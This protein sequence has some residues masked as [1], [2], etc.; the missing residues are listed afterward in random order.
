MQAFSAACWVQPGLGEPV[1]VSLGHGASPYL[2]ITLGPPRYS[3]TISLPKYIEEQFGLP[4]D[5]TH[6]KGELLALG[7]LLRRGWVVLLWVALLLTS[8]PPARYKLRA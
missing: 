3:A 5:V 1:S 6:K 2:T 8:P 4:P 7:E